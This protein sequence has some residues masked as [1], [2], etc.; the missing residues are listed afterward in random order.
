[1]D[2]NTI[3]QKYI[4]FNVSHGHTKIAPAA[5][6]LEGDPTTLFTGSGMQ[7]LMPYLL[8]KKHP[9]GTRLTDSQPCVRAQDID[10][11]GDNRHT[12]FFEML[13]NWSL[14][15]YFKEEQIRWFF[16]FLT[17]EIGLEASK[18]YVSCFQ[19][20]KAYGI[21]RDDEA[22]LIWQKVFKEAGIEAK[23]VEIGAASNGDERGINPDERIFFYD[24]RE[25]WWSRGGG[26]DS[27]PI[28]DPCGPDS[29]VFYD[30]GEKAHDASFGKAHPASDSGRFLEIGNQV[31]MQ[32]RRLEDGSFEPLKNKNV[33]FG[34]GL[35]RIAAA[36]LDTPDVFKTSLFMPVIEK[37][38][39]LSGKKY[40]AHVGSMRVIA[41]HIKGATFL[42]SQG[43]APS[44]KEQGYVMRRLLRRAVRKA[45]ELGVEQNFLGEVVP[46]LADIY[47]DF[48]PVMA[49]NKAEVVEVLEREEKAFRKTLQKGL[50]E[51]TRL[52]GTVPAKEVGGRELFMLYD[53]YGFPV[54]L[55]TEEA[56]KQDIALSKNWRDEF[57]AAMKEQ[58]ERSQTAAKGTFKGGLKDHSEMSTKYH[59]A[60][61]LT[62]AALQKVLGGE[63]QQKGSN[64]T[65]ERLRFDFSWP[66]KLTPSQ[67]KAVEDQVNAWI[68]ADLPITYDE[69]DTDYAF[70][71]LH[72]HGSFRERY[73]DRVTV[74]T[75][76]DTKNPTSCE[77]CGGPHVERTSVIGEGD[78]KYKITKE[79]AS[80]A[81]VRRIKAV[82]Q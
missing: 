56:F 25:N 54:E 43:L 28:G 42:A 23:I 48:Y 62:L 51:L 35:E 36:A 60:T 16:E 12:T 49:Q 14:G 37:L 80:S 21:P 57:D 11:V 69:Y 5:L 19:G 8:G 33:D 75:I 44:N 64:I 4:D 72:A 47:A 68:E 77:I 71:T 38:E 24:D 41:D 65:A 40:D 53:T 46:V 20:S 6:V 27:T 10:D 30:F 61:H 39:Q 26:L 55:S 70:D 7:P 15:D 17:H 76:G 81:G 22:A 45:F 67:T 79:E 34:G 13:G 73:G 2:A 9:K 31:F 63:V 29:E 58:R 50:K 78:K 18:I 32:Y 52:A 82:L 3:R 74:Y 59:T 66:E 1:M